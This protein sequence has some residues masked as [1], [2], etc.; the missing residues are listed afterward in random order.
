MKIFFLK[1]YK[2]LSLLRIIMKELMLKVNEIEPVYG[3][4]FTSQELIEN[5][6][7]NGWNKIAPLPVV[8]IPSCLR[9]DGK[10]YSSWDGHHRYNAAINTSTHLIN[11][12][13]YGED[14]DFERAKS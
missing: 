8:E 4:R 13:L 14:D 1:V 10:R 12:V 5:I 9:I 11:C 6:K 7:N 2:Y 3:S